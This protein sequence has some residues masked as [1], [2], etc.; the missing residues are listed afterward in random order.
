MMVHLPLVIAFVFVLPCNGGHFW[1]ISDL[2]LDYLY[3]RGGNLSNLC[4]QKASESENVTTEDQVVGPYGN[5]NCDSP[6]ALVESALGAMKKFHPNP[7]FILWTGDS[8]PHW[9][10][11][12]PPN[13]EY[14][15]NV[16]KKI[17]TK[18]EDLFPNIS[19]VPCLGNH[20]ASPPDQFPVSS[21]NDTSP[22]Y[23]E[24]LLQLGAFKEHVDEETFKKCGFYSKTM[25]PKN[26]NMKL[27]FIVLNTNI[28]YHDN[29]TTGED[30]CGQMEWLNKTLNETGSDERVFIV[31]HVPPGSFERIPGVSNF[32]SPKDFHEE[33]QKKYVELVSHRDYTPKIIAHLYG[34]LHTDTF[35]VFLDSARQREAVGVAFMSGSVTPILWE[36]GKIV[37][38]NPTMRLMKYS[39]EDATLEDYSVYTLDIDKVNSSEIVEKAKPAGSDGKMNESQVAKSRRKNSKLTRSKRS[40][41]ED[42]SNSK[43]SKRVLP[44]ETTETEKSIVNQSITVLPDVVNASIK[45]D[46]TNITVSHVTE[47]QENKLSPESGNHDD[48]SMNQKTSQADSVMVKEKEDD[49]LSKD[50]INRWS[51]LYKASTSFGVQDLTPASMFEAV[52][53]MVNGGETHPVFKEYYEHN[54]G[55]HIK[56]DNCNRT[57]WRGHLCT[58]TK[59]VTQELGK[60]LNN[61]G[62]EGF[63]H[64]ASNAITTSKGKQLP[65][66]NLEIKVK[67]GSK[68]VKDDGHEKS[69]NMNIDIDHAKNFPEVTDN[70][71][72]SKQKIES[73]VSVDVS[74]QAVGIFFG[75]LGVISIALLVALGYKKYKNNRYRNQEFLLT[76]AVFRYDGYSQLD[77][78]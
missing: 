20:D 62:K 61:K 14:I 69:K 4:H 38:V 24:K 10:E 46:N 63:Y 55:G 27:K 28:Y 9:R 66:D 57:C 3:V 70:F 2:H 36:S 49:A 21:F 48:E 45:E 76:D 44:S 54:T 47:H 43:I 67:N 50:L 7:E 53:T 15:F 32:N 65:D 33:I 72:V 17:F 12:N 42:E 40:S 60:C 35:R 18:L 41:S 22:D 25:E 19:I 29:K 23:Y 52:K 71:T 16:T 58:I 68:I 13:E 77:D 30:P 5:Y 64:E 39:D 26:S 11:P 75:V 8:A 6:E 31:A 59:L 56:I 74:S 1:H 37:G 73:E 34:H 78:M 51:L